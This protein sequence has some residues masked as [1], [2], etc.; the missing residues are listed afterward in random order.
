MWLPEGEWWDLFSGE[1]REGG[2]HTVYGDLTETPVYARAGAIV[3]MGAKVPWGGLENPD[4]LYLHVFP[5]ADN[6]LELYEDD[7]ATVAYKEGRYALT[8]I[9][10]TWQGDR[11]EIGIGP[12]QRGCGRDGGRAPVDRGGAWGRAA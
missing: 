5:G 2:W 7:G 11:M 10:V 12:V 3:P 4:T 8:P 1:R 6:R 9:E